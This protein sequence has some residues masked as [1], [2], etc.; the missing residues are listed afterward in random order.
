MDYSEFD[1]S[2]RYRKA[3][4]SIPSLLEGV[5][6]NRILLDPKFSYSKSWPT[7]VKS[8]F[9]EGVL[10]GMPG[11]EIICE[12]SSYGDLVVLDGAQRLMCLNEFFDDDFKLQ[13]LRLI[14]SLEGCR[15]SQLPYGQASVFQNR[16]EFG[17]TIISYDTDPILKFE[18]F[19]RI[20]SEAYR[21]PVQLARNYAFREQLRFIRALQEATR[22]HLHPDRQSF[23]ELTGE[24]SRA[25]HRQVSDFDELYLG[26]CSAVLVYHNR[27]SPSRF[28]YV[29]KFGDFLDE[30]AIHLHRSSSDFGVLE[31]YVKR[32]LSITTEY[33]NSSIIF[34]DSVARLVRDE[35]NDGRVA[36]NS[37][38]ILT[39]FIGSLKGEPVSLD[40]ARAGR[41]RYR[42]NSNPR[43]FF[44][45]ILG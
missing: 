29:A 40:R 22:R 17:L 23:R 30:T 36:L 3:V 28:R 27:I 19:K 14:P 35:S 18:F 8:A 6:S 16:A 13:G 39:C 12:E 42:S 5:R 44:S 15:Y 41:F 37:S 4:R 2:F 38:S 24:P 34:D 43:L 45:Q 7:S 21:F 1:R 9:I 25:A 20:H 31:K 10:V 26:M 32:V 33:L 11:P